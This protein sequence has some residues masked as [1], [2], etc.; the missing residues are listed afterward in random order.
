MTKIHALLVHKVHLAPLEPMENMDPMDEKAKL[1]LKVLAQDTNTNQ[2]H[3]VVR[4]VPLD[5]KEPLDPLDLLEK[6]EE[7]VNPARKVEMANLV[8]A[9]QAQLEM[10]VLL[11]PMEHLVP[12]EKMV[13]MQRV[14]AKGLLEAKDKMVDPAQLEDPVIKVLMVTPDPLDPLDH[15]DLQADLVNRPAKEML[16]PLDPLANLAQM[17]N[18]VLVQDARRNTYNKH[19][20]DRGAWERY[21]LSRHHPMF[22]IDSI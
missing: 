6:L 12:K 2:A 10:Q 15:P 22:C 1:A 14:E 9:P 13:P 21:G 3:P 19:Q 8:P 16:D 17:P 7:K 5:P 4:N 11:V 20:Y 18:I